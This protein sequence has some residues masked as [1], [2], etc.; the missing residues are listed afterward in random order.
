MLDAIKYVDFVYI[1]ND[2]TPVKPV[3]ILKP[4][5]VLKGGDY[6]I[7]RITE[8]DI[9]RLSEDN[10]QRLQKINSE[11]Y[12]KR[13]SEILL[14]KSSDKSLLIKE[15]NEIVETKLVKKSD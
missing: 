15:F 11:D 4:D 10:I 13:S 6:Y 1:F 8:D 14:N 9:R 5:I 2:E 12:Q 3:E 7:T